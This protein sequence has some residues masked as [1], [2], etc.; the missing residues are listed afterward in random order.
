MGTEAE[1][2]SLVWCTPSVARCA[3]LRVIVALELHFQRVHRQ[4]V[5]CVLMSKDSRGA[6]EMYD[7]YCQV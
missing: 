6:G 4:P 2:A 3:I 5:A 1:L 7:P